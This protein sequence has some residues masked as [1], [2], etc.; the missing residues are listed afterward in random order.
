[1]CPCGHA[2]LPEYVYMCMYVCVSVC[3]SE[4]VHV[5]VYRL[6]LMSGITLNYH[7]TYWGWWLSQTPSSI[8]AILISQLALGNLRS[9]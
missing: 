1:L 3:V 9:Q 7:I 6:I 8:V 4:C 2:Y 5:Y